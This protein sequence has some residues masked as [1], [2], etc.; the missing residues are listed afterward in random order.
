MPPQTPVVAVLARELGP[1]PPDLAPVAD[2]ATIRYAVSVHELKDALADAD[3]L[4]AWDFRSPKLRDAWPHARRLQWVHVAGVGVEAV[5]FP[6]LASSSVILTNSRGV[7]DEAIAEYVLGLMLA[8][9][10]GLPVTFDLQ[11]R[12]AWQHRETERLAGQMVL[13]LGAGGI[14]R[15]I[16]RL[17]RGAGMHVV[18]VARTARASDPEL[19]RVA[20]LRDLE[21]FLPDADYVVIALPLTS[22]TKGMVGAAALGRMKPTARLINVARGPIVD[23]EALVQALR[24]GRIAG[25]A[26]DVFT[27][28]PL[29]ADSPFWDLPGVIV[30]PHMSGD[31]AGWE[32]SLSQL[33]VVNFRRWRRGEPLLNIVDKR[34][35]YVPTPLDSPPTGEPAGT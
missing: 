14:G 22:D 13:V 4:L 11:R 10:I 28:E 21:A 6:E 29:P 7:F 2:E 30:S 16:G 1:L 12:H 27:E 17:A 31:F 20:A 25:A 26:L 33:F 9:A 8:F 23:E 3:V 24:A 32:S 15:A 34:R 19:G 18:G 35:G 5:L